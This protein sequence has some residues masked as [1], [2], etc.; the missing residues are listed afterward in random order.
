MPLTDFQ[1]NN[2]GASAFQFMD[3]SGFN[4]A[5]Q[6]IPSR[7]STPPASPSPA[8]TATPT[9][10]TPQTA[11]PAQPAITAPTLEPVDE[12]AVR[13]KVRSNM[14]AQI[15]AINAQYTNLISQE[16]Q[17]GQERSGETRAINA[18]S[19]ITDSD[20]GA[21]QDIK[22]QQFNQQQVKALQ[23]EQAAKISAVQANIEDRAS[24]EI[25]NERKNNLDQYN[26][27]EAAYQKAQEQAVNDLKT[28]A[29]AGVKLDSLDPNQKAALLKQAGYSDPA[30]GEVVYN[31]MLPKAAQIDYKSE[32]LGNGQVLF[33]G[34][35]P[36]T[37][38]L[39]TQKVS[40]D[41]PPDASLTIAPD[42][43]PIIFDKTTG[44][45]K[46]APGFSQGQF[47]KATATASTSG[48]VAG[49]NPAVDGWVQNIGSGAAKFSDVPA[50]LKT[51]VSNG[52]AA[53]HGSADDILAT[54]KQ[55]L[56]ELQDMV[57]NDK[58]FTA[59]VGAK[60]ISSLFG[61]KGSP[62]AGTAAAN[63]D[64][65]LKQVTN[66]V[67]LPNLKILH[68]LGRVTDREF[69][70]LQSAVT[71]LGTNLSESQFK[72]E[73]EDITNQINAAATQPQT[74]SDSSNIDLSQFEK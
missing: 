60:G 17:N 45:A 47:A 68:G 42:G 2:G 65:K 37:G 74:T 49:A 66:D 33:Y 31:A 6:L 73:L 58:G 20:F 53:T 64:A 22:T 24:A 32:N 69:Q 28:L 41:M 1:Q 56:A 35:D 71:S 34:L 61:L 14:Q 7:Y 9:V 72:K 38:Q 43:T 40:V 12:D 21:A 4:S 62:F 23:D 50:A 5:G 27:Q 11:Q 3:G 30:M 51:A 55:S 70:A 46:I 63:F 13:E 48:Y 29:G 52:L 44:E 18:R 16:Q 36:T 67:V 39:K 26:V 54:T 59:A 10:A 15:D 8:P 19:G 25:E 57:N